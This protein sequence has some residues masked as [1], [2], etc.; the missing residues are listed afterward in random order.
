MV[1]VLA[2]GSDEAL[3]DRRSPVRDFVLG[4]TGK[5]RPR[6]LFVPTATGDRPPSIVE[7]YSAFEAEQCV[8]HH[9]GLFDRQHD[10]L[11]VF[12]R[13]FDVILVPGGNTANLLYLW[14]RHG[15]DRILRE[16]FDDAANSNVVFAGGSAG[17]I[18]WFEGGTTDSF[19]P[20][21]RVFREGLGL[22]DGSFCPHYDGEGQRRPLYHEAVLAGDLPAG[23][24][25]GDRDFVHFDGRAFVTAIST[26]DSPVALRVEARDG[27]IVETPLPVRRL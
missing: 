1:H 13:S 4:L 20:T 23:Y 17:A 15:V 22:L 3:M 27:E 25:C 10:D 11:D 8:P 26:S 6:V 16:M 14:K 5:G 12:V 19:G 24:A 9:L 2:G 7:F 18:C 21:L